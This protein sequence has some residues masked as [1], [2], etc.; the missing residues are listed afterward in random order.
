M[1]H[2]AAENHDHHYDP[3]G[4]RFGMWL[5]LFTEILLFGGLFIVYAVYRYANSEA[6]HDASANLSIL[7]G[8]VNTVV[9]LTSSL[10]VAYSITAMQKGETKRS[11]WFLVVTIALAGLFLVIKYFEWKAKYDYGI[12]PGQE[13]FLQMPHG[14]ILFF[15]LYFFMTGLHAVHVVIGMILLGII[16]RHI[17][18]GTINPRRYV[19]LENSG[20]Y[21]HIV[22]VV[23]IFLFPLLYLII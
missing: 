11:F 17:W 10:T 20:L 18:R 9:L 21:W 23:W 2:Q 16:A 13:G 19:Y 12:F 5:F 8:A 22:D 14:E 4:I 3:T 1:S 15:S 6:F 7:H